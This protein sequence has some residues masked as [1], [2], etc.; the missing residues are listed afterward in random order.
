MHLGPEN[1]LCSA[2]SNMLDGWHHSQSLPHSAV[3]CNLSLCNAVSGA[4][5]SPLIS[6]ITGLCCCLFLKWSNAAVTSVLR[7]E[8]LVTVWCFNVL[9]ALCSKKTAA[10]LITSSYVLAVTSVFLLP[11]EW[12][13]CCHW[14]SK[15][16]LSISQMRFC[17]GWMKYTVI[18]TC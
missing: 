14:A 9:V 15:G 10:L 8:V 2:N 16:F 17:L 1:I 12:Q 4:I 6:L 18:G 11:L 13:I 7:R 5:C 3:P